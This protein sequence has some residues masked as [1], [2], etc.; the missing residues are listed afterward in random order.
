M[1]TIITTF[2]ITMAMVISAQEDIAKNMITK[3][4]ISIFKSQKE[5]LAGHVQNKHAAL[6]GAIQY[7]VLAV[8]EFKKSNFSQAV[9]YTSKAREY[10]TEILSGAN[11]PG[12][13]YYLLT[14]DEKQMRTTN[15]CSASENLTPAIIGDPV[16]MDPEQ[17]RRDYKISLN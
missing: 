14:N 16:L 15:N 3:T 5:M 9:C 11:V 6:S 10:T 2:F 1:R 12:L 7:Q 4:E 17:L 8:E 13:D